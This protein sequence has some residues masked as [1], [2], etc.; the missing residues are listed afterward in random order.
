VLLIACG[1]SVAVAPAP[2]ATEG[3]FHV[4]ITNQ[5]PHIDPVD[6][7]VRVDDEVLVSSEFAWEGGY[8]ARGW[9]KRL[10]IGEHT[11]DV[12]SAR[13]DAHLR[14]TF[15]QG[16]EPDWGLVEYWYY[17]SQDNSGPVPKHLEWSISNTPPSI[18]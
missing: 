11:V 14:T 6:V 16:A 12:V 4:V 2:T 7:T 10:S 3:D 15:T 1:G 18:E 5:S 8:L 13:G 9:S 17:T